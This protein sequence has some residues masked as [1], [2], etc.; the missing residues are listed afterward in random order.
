MDSCTLCFGYRLGDGKGPKEPFLNAL[1]HCLSP[2]G[3]KV[4]AGLYQANII[5]M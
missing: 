2:A 4:N 1:H 3:L 5:S